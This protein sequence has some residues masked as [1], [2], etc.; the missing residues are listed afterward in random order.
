MPE[1]G[2]PAS[3]G[4]LCDFAD[5]EL[6]HR[7]QIAVMPNRRQFIASLA[8]IAG[9]T[10]VPGVSSE[11]VR[12]KRQPNIIFFLVDDLGWGDL[13][14]YADKF[15]ETPHIDRLCVEGLKFTNAYAA[16]PVCSPSRAAILT[17]KAPGRLHLTQ[18]IPGSLYPH[19]KLLEAPTPSHLDLSIP[20]IAGQLKGVGYQTGAIGKWHLGGDGYL[21]ENFGF[22]SNVAGDS[23]GQPGPPNHYFGPFQYHNLTGYTSNDYLTEV[24]TSKLEEFISRAAPQGP[25]FLYMAEYAVHIPLQARQAL[26]EKYRR[27]NGGKE[28]PDPVYAAMVET[29]DTALGILRA[30]LERSG[31][32][33]HTV[34]ILTSDN[35]GV[36]FQRRQLHRIADNGP[37]RAGKG[38]LYEGGIREPLIVHWPGV[39]KRGAVCEVPVTGTDFLPTIL[40]LAGV[41]SLPSPCDGLDIGKLL[42]GDTS[43]G[44]EALYWHYPHY[45]DQG[46]APS[47]AIREGD[48]KL[49]EFFEDGHLELYN[50]AL[51]PGE[52]YNFASSFEDKASD[53]LAKLQSWRANVGVIM[54]TPNPEYNPLKAELRIGPSGCSWDPLSLCLED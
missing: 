29:V 38:F 24:L 52:Q 6:N 32:A 8:G 12:P 33:D 49:I 36:G 10:L 43:L 28:D 54:P 26:V 34:I 22:D 18:W 51:D 41:H 13:G 40:N 5:I 2:T 42:R 27:K 45:S 44:R 47:G 11:T 4:G 25:F 7:R 48:W 30:T 14:C 16:A 15:H 39:T 31:V 3:P 1:S 50:L 21:P 35:G 20:T 53:L 23:Q 46:G 37:W 19:K 17:G 9:A